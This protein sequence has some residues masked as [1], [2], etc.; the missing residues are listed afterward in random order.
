MLLFFFGVPVV[1]LW[2]VWAAIHWLTDWWV[3]VDYAA[4][5]AAII[6]TTL[7]AIVVALNGAMR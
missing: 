7:A 1:F 4:F 5:A 6:G 3:L 2:S